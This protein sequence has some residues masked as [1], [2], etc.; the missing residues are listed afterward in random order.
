MKDKNEIG[1]TLIEL[2]V[3]MAVLVIL[4]TV[5]VP[6]AVSMTERKRVREAMESLVSAV[7]IARSEAASKS[8]FV[9]L[10]VNNVSDALAFGVSSTNGCDPLV[11]NSCVVSSATITNEYAFLYDK[12][13]Y[14]NPT[15]DV[16][17][18]FDP[19]TSVLSVSPASAFSF[20][21]GSTAFDISTDDNSYC[22]RL[23]LGYLG[24][25][26]VVNCP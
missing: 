18:I 21:A 24:Q 10:Q 9:Y 17:L 3:T 23:E 4:V 7:Y 1:I 20:N 12:I 22:R 2:M 16:S 6:A 11:V 13:T 19:F 14:K 15:S 5:A 8:E 26:H 25:V